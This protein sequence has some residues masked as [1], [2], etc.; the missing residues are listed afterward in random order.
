[1]D[2]GELD[3]MFL[4]DVGGYDA[5]QDKTEAEKTSVYVKF[6]NM[7]QRE[8]ESFGRSVLEGMPPEVPAEDAV[9]VQRVMEAAYRANDEK[10]IIS[11]Q[12]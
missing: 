2:G 6:G 5:A 10:K 8:I 3:A 7:Y 1:V 9:Q 12:L 4:S 11:M